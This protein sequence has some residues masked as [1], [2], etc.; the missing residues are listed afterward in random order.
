MLPLLI[1]VSR[2]G[3]EIAYSGTLELWMFG[4]DSL[5]HIGAFVLMVIAV[6]ACGLLW[7]LSYL[8]PRVWVVWGVLLAGVGASLVWVAWGLPAIMVF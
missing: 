4:P 3:G 6:L 1:Y 5:A 8:F 2:I 7:F